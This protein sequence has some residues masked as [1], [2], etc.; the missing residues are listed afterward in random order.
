MYH[1]EAEA[2]QG[3]NKKQKIGGEMGS[4]LFNF[5]KM[6]FSLFGFVNIKKEFATDVYEESKKSPQMSQLNC[7]KFS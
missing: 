1:V 4:R 3:V 6:F 2:M 7:R 5:I